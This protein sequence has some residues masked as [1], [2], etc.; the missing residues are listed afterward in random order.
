MT[1]REAQCRLTIV[2]HN[3]AEQTTNMYGRRRIWHAKESFCSDTLENGC[4]DSVRAT[5]QDNPLAGPRSGKNQLSFAVCCFYI[6]STGPSRVRLHSRQ[7]IWIC[8]MIRRPSDNYQSCLPRYVMVGVVA[9]RTRNNNHCCYAIALRL[10]CG[11]PNRH[12]RK[13][14]NEV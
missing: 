3:Q 9:I 7:P 2:P 13:I 1:G 10:K 6:E 11:R 12:K 8:F 5:V 4:T 14:L